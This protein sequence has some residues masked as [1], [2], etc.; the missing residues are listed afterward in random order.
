MQGCFIIPAR[1]LML[2]YYST[3]FT[4]SP[5]TYRVFIYNC[6][7]IPRSFPLH[8]VTTPPGSAR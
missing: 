4:V 1:E 8:A 2:E 6:S 7:K 3:I 5:Q